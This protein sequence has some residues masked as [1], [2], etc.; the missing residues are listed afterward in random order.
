[1]RVSEHKL[2]ILTN[3]TIALGSIF[4]LGIILRVVGVFMFVRGIKI[5]YVLNLIM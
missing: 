3:I 5:P 1:L 4:L 2:A